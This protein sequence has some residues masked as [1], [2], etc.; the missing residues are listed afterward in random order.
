MGMN[1]Y[2]LEVKTR[3]G[4]F[5]KSSNLLRIEA[6]NPIYDR[7]MEGYSNEFPEADL[8]KMKSFVLEYPIS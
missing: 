8:T 5:R 1:E 3:G 2:T 7:K 4:S 6:R